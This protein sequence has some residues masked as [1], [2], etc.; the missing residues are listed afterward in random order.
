MKKAPFALNGTNNLIALPTGDIEVINHTGHPV[1][2]IADFASRYNNKR[3]VLIT[4]KLLGKY[5]PTRPSHITSAQIELASKFIP[6][7]HKTLFIGFAESCSGFGHGLFEHILDMNNQLIGKSA[8]IHTTRQF[9]QDKHK[10]AI[11]FKEEHSH[12]VNQ[13]VM[14]PERE[15]IADIFNN[16]ETIVLLED[17]ITTGNT[18]KNL[19]NEYLENINSKIKRVVILT[20]LDVREK[21]HKVGL[22][23]SFSEIAIMTHSLSEASLRFYKK[24]DND[25]FTQK[26]KFQEKK[27]NII[28]ETGRQGILYKELPIINA[29]SAIE[30]KVTKDDKLT[31]LGT[32]EFSHWPKKIAE[33]LE[34][35]GYDTEVLT[36]TRAPLKVGNAIKNKITIPDHYGEGIEHY[37]YNLD[38]QRK[39]IFCY[40]SSE[41]AELHKEL[42]KLLDAIIVIWSQ[43]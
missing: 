41:Q 36:T 16:A 28:L 24:Y 12:A 31:V 3:H 22:I 6:I 26:K 19:L 4:S 2:E 21:S 11:A 9:D 35:S 17:E 33:E 25:T 8:Y 20:I 37:I 43:K 34:K 40:E 32:S 7:N 29:V 23:K 15:D 18:I 1:E 10:L 39:V 38:T 27:L 5:I 13:V 14:K 30:D 42:H